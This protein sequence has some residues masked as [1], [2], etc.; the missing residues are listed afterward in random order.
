MNHTAPPITRQIIPS[1]TTTARATEDL[2]ASESGTSVGDRVCV[3]GEPVG[4]E[5]ESGTA[6]GDAVEWKVGKMEG[7]GVVGA[8]VGCVTL[9]AVLGAVVGA[10]LGAAL[11]TVLGAMLGAKLG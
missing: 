9:G 7:V 3:V 6:V 4:S 1:T 11:G 10:A 8:E 5:G 2:L